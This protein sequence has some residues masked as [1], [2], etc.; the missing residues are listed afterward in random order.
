MHYFSY[1]FSK[2]RQTLG[3]FR[4]QRLL[5]FNIGDLKLRDL[6]IVVF[7]ADYDEIDL[8]NRVMTSFQ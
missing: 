6:A 5:T 7:E 1:K 2:N 8:Q 3:A 4:P